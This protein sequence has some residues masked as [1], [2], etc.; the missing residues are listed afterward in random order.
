MECVLNAIALQNMTLVVEF[1][2]RSREAVGMPPRH[3]AEKV[4]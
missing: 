2:R 4:A 3:R 1:E